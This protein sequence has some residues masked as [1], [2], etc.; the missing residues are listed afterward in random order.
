M[1]SGMR[2]GTTFGLALLVSLTWASASSAQ[3]VADFYK[4][5]IV[6]LQVGA[7]VGSGYDV[8][9]RAIA[10]YWPKHLPGNPKFVVQNVPGAGGVVML[11][12]LAHKA[13]TDGTV[14]GAAV[15]ASIIDPVAGSTVVRYDP[16]KLVWVGNMTSTYTACFVRKDSPVKSFED[17][18]R[19][20]T[21]V[22]AT[23]VNS[24]GAVL[25]YAFNELIGTKF[26]VVKG[27][28]APPDMMLAVER[29]EVDGICLAYATMMASNP[30]AIEQQKITWLTVVNDKPIADLPGVPPVSQFIPTAEG[31]QILGLLVARNVIGR[32]FVMPEGV[33]AD[34][35][36]AV[37]RS[38]MDTMKDPEFIAEANKLKLEIEPMD[39]VQVEAMI[40]GAYDTPADIVQK[41]YAMMRGAE[42]AGEKAQSVKK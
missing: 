22:A 15:A 8:Y 37:R 31:R 12:N 28:K 32:P 3:P 1:G 23:S 16:R 19:I 33:P 13:S 30:T 11:N 5:K 27:Y 14:M 17:A 29:G 4:G 34:R 41:A 7:G 24:S 39:H 18:K 25:S 21:T 36:E 6:T 10:R 9:A 2:S 40:K 20:E 26:R 38:F 42:A 35:A